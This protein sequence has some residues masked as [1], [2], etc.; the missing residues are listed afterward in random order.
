MKVPLPERSALFE[1]FYNWLTS[2]GA[3]FE[4]LKIAKFS[5]YDYGV[6]SEKEIGQGDLLIAIPRKL[7][8]TSESAKNS[9]LGKISIKFFFNQIIIDHT[10]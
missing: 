3:F 6:M 10:Y 9:L 2:N 7:M 1:E 4:G 5:G 8:L